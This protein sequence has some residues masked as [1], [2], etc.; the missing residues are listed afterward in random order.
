MTHHV[1]S[2]CDRPTAC[3]HLHP[4]LCVPSSATRR[5]PGTGFNWAPWMLGMRAWRSRGPPSVDGVPEVPRMP[6]HPQRPSERN[7]SRHYRIV[8]HPCHHPDVIHT[9]AAFHSCPRDIWSTQRAGLLPT[10]V[11]SVQG[12]LYLGLS[13]SLRKRDFN[14]KY[15]PIDLLVINGLHASKASRPFAWNAR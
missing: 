3:V 4:V 7:V 15:S 13:P 8:Y 9:Y 11:G 10:H 5:D 2:E 12:R 1:L 14:S 6:S